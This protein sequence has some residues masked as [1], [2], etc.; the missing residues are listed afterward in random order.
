MDN[1]T[2]HK[3]DEKD[4]G[5][6]SIAMTPIY[7]KL[8]YQKIVGYNGI[9]K[10]DTVIYKDK[11]YTVVMVSRLGHFG[12]SETDKLPYKL[13]VR[14]DEVVKQVEEEYFCSN[15]NTDEY[16]SFDLYHTNN[17]IPYDAA[18]CKKCGKIIW[19]EDISE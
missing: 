17:G 11:E 6:L 9:L 18:Y 4:K 14:P 2:W 3:V 7:E 12:L 16:V 13:C 1:I 5:I 8:D 10:G 19:Q 15:C